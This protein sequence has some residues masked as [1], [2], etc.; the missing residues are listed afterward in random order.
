MSGVVSTGVPR[1][2][3]QVGV[4]GALLLALM[5]WFVVDAGVA[6]A[7]RF[8]PPWQSEVVV[9]RTVVYSQPDRGSQPVGPLPRGAIVVVWGEMQGADGEKWLAIPDGFLP[10]GDVQ[11]KFDSW[12]GEVAQPTVSV[13]AKPFVASGVRRTVRLG[14][15][16]RVTGVSAGLE[17]DDNLWWA[18]TEGFLPLDSVRTATGEWA[19][20]W[21]LPEASEAAGGWWGAVSSQ[22]NVR[23]GSSLDAP[24]VGQFAGG[25]RIKVLAEEEGQAINGNGVWYRIDGGRFA[26][27][28][29]HS[30]LVRKL[31]DPR[32]NTTA[33]SD[34]LRDSWIVVDRS[35][36]SLT[37]VEGGEAK[38]VT[39]VSLGQAGVD[40]PT[41]SYSTMGKFRGDRMSSRNVANPTRPYDLPNVPYTQYYLDGGFAIH[42]T[43]WHDGFGTPESQGCINLTWTDAAYLFSLTV[44]EVPEGV[45]ERWAAPEA[46]TRVVIL[47]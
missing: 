46:A 10:S 41:G 39:Y 7:Q 3:R 22:A 8:G 25:E 19:Q 27:A 35:A 33:P 23:L 34:G 40:T 32:P 44:P 12:V 5:L 13:Y 30:S 9:E 14:D 43:Y 29:I 20:R 26:G 42:G 16:L 17:G 11:E 28:R 31:P 38:F 45:N 47:G 37:F 21:S 18:T 6:R 24:V 2:L 1:W 4:V 15:L 36:S